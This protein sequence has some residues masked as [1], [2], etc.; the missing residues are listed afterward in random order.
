MKTGRPW[1]ANLSMVNTEPFI[2]GFFLTV[3][4]QMIWFCQIV[5]KKRF[6]KYLIR[7]SHLVISQLPVVSSEHVRRCIGR[8]SIG[9]FWKQWYCHHRLDLS[10]IETLRPQESLLQTLYCQAT[11]SVHLPGVVS[12]RFK[13]ITDISKMR[14]HSIYLILLFHNFLTS[15]LTKFTNT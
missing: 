5:L 4:I 3:E 9:G 13:V 8:Q 6:K 1:W 7:L 11:G 14:R 10:R 2:V 12:I 15:F